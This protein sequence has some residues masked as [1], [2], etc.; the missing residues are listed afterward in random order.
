MLTILAR[1]AAAHLTT[2]PASE[3]LAQMTEKQLIGVAMQPNQ[4]NGAGWVIHN[5][6]HTMARLRI[7]TGPGM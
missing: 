3:E 5:P 4:W 7:A 1:I 2:P 6:A